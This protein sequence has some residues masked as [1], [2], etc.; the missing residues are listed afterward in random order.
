MPSVTIKADEFRYPGL[1]E[2]RKVNAE[3][4]GFTTFDFPFVSEIAAIINNFD[5]LDKITR[6]STLY[7]WEHCLVNR[8]G[9]LRRAYDLA[10]VN[11]NRG[12]P[13]DINEYQPSH[14]INRGQFGFY[15]ETYFYFFISVRD[16]LAHLINVYCAM[17]IPEK[18]VYINKE[19][20]N[21]IP[22]DLIKNL[23]TAFLADT[24]ITSE[25][26]N[27]LAHRYL[28]T[29]PDQRP[30]VSNENCKTYFG[31]SGQEIKSSELL[32]EIKRSFSCLLD[33][34]TALK[35]LLILSDD[36]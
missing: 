32:A 14:Y 10:L 30:R 20:C 27:S 6:A 5:K 17:G 35:P 18:R 33:F 22:D 9:S 11:Y 4:P 23:F 28:P 21:K 19:F 13:D 26:R 8:L 24:E 12:L 7:W 36:E 1:E 34:L 3:T 15:G 25:Y 31:A 2:L 16:T 29:Q